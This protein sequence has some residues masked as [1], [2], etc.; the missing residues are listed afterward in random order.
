MSTDPKKKPDTEPAA[1]PGKAEPAPPPAQEPPTPTPEPPAPPATDPTPAADPAPDPA[2]ELAALRMELQ[3]ANAKLAAY[4]AGAPAEVVDDAVVLALHDL[5]QTGA[6][7]TA[8]TLD[9]A[10]T[11][12]L[13]RHPDWQRH[14]P[15]APVKAGAP[16][17]EPKP[18]N[19]TLPSGTVSF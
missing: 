10:V 15:P 18:T 7:V 16:E 3:T 17:P 11:S 13:Q 4:K 1:D 19:K 12:V 5:Q 2:E 6:A 9:D 14:T 8:Q